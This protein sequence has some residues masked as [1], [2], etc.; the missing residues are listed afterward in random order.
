MHR[1]VSV[2]IWKE[3]V[4]NLYLVGEDIIKFSMTIRKERYELIFCSE[5]HNENQ[6]NVT[7]S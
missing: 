4:M 3:H 2:N 1:Y 7:F 6:I 5:K